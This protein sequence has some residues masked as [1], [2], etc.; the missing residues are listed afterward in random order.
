M[1]SIVNSDRTLN[2]SEATQKQAPRWI[3]SACLTIVLSASG[4]LLAQPV[5]NADNGHYY[6]AVDVPMG[7]LEARVAAEN[8][9]PVGFKSYLATLT[10]QLEQ[11]FVSQNVQGFE[12]AWLGGYQP[13]PYSNAAEGWEWVTEEAWVYENWYTGEP[14]DFGGIESYLMF[15]VDSYWNDQY[16]YAINPYII[17]YEPLSIQIDGRDTGVLDV[18]LFD[19]NGIY[20]ISELIED[21]ADGAT[22]HGEFVSSVSKITTQLKDAGV[23]TGNQKGA[24]QKCAAQAAIP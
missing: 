4:P 18:L 10:S 8:A 7:W 12:G 6:E 19:D 2:Q 16:D 1:Q 24:I 11:D 13:N 5:L 3:R 20:S 17:E 9:A 23:I 15:W 14:N 21:C 22:N